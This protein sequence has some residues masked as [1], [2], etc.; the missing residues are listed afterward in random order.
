MRPSVDDDVIE[1][2]N[3][4]MILA[5]EPDELDPEHWSVFQIKGL[6]AVF[7]GQT[8]CFGFASFQRVGAEIHDWQFNF[9]RGHD[10]EFRLTIIVSEGAAQGLMAPDDFIYCFFENDRV[11]A[12]AY[13]EIEVIVVMRARFELVQKP[14]SL[15]GEGERRLFN[16]AFGLNRGVSILSRFC[17]SFSLFG[18]GTCEG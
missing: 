18:D 8:S 5:G 13:P 9:E 11:Q 2:D 4:Q 7:D 10:G 16:S 17:L 14:N 12:S 1:R 15:L 3:Q 6:L